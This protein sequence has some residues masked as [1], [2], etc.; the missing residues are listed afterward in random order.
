MD[1][2]LLEGKGLTFGRLAVR[3][4]ATRG[5]YESLV[6]SSLYI[7]Q[8]RQAHTLHVSRVYIKHLSLA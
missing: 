3:A 2:L 5:M 7:L 8:L 6:F 4:V 1:A